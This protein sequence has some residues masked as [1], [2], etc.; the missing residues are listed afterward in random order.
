[1]YAFREQI[2]NVSMD[3][4]TPGNRSTTVATEF[5][6]N[7]HRSRGF[8]LY[9]SLIPFVNLRGSARANDLHTLHYKKYIYFAYK[10]NVPWKN[11]HCVYKTVFFFKSSSIFE[12]NRTINTDIDTY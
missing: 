1:M 11:L 7:N 10:H 5:N 8:Q 2:S 12:T 4:Y 3:S 6:R 9:S